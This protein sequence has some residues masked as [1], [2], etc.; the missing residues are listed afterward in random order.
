MDTL[1]SPVLRTGVPPAL[2]PETIYV[3]PLSLVETTVADARATRRDPYQGAARE[4]APKLAAR[5]DRPATA[6]L[7]PAR[8]L[9]ALAAR[10]ANDAA[11]VRRV[12]R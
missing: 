9:E 3:A 10:T 4:T 12:T 8:W 6:R 7:H 5:E 11:Q 2:T 1:T